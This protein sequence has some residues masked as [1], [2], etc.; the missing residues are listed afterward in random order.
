MHFPDARILLFAKAPQPGRVKTRLIPALGAGG[1]ATLYRELLVATLGRIAGAG[2]A[3]LE[4]CCAP[5]PRHPLFLQLQRRHGL[6]LSRQQGCDLGGRME[7]AACIALQRARMV[8]LIGGDCPGLDAAYVERALAALRAGADAVIGPA[9]D[10]GYVLLGLSR[11]DGHLF[12][13]MPWGSDRVLDE[14]RQRLR[15][16][17]WRWRELEPLWDL[18]RPRDLAR[19]RRLIRDAAAGRW[20]APAG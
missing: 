1:A 13:G 19:Y 11:I 12:R 20:P 9:E 8:V 6:E 7:H 17:D 10:G 2:L 15:R 5:D 3:P 14:T 18:D 4:C 16:L